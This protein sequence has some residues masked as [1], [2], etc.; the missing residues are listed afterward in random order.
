MIYEELMKYDYTN[1]QNQ[2]QIAILKQKQSYE[3]KSPR[4]FNFWNTQVELIKDKID[5]FQLFT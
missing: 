5:T 3:E 2:L 4:A 1:L